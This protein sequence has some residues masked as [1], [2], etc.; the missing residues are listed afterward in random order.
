MIG[1]DYVLGFM[2]SHDLDYVAL[3]LKV[4]PEWQIGKF[5]GIGGKV[6]IGRG[7]TPIGAMVREF[8]EETGVITVESHW[9][10]VAVGYFTGGRVFIFATNSDSIF[11][12]KQTTP[13]L[14]ILFQAASISNS[15]NII[16]NLKW[17]IPLCKSILLM[18]PEYRPIH[19]IEASL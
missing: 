14:P 1:T 6:E 5:N 16:P 12:I 18:P 17:W 3:I 9:V 10:K 11:E 2:F 8:Y 7:E 19:L 15:T 4:K 13:E